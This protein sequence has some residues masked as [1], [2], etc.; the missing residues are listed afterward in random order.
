MTYERT[1]ATLASTDDQGDLATSSETGG[2]LDGHA[3]MAADDSAIGRSTVAGTWSGF[4][5]DTDVLS[6]RTWSMTGP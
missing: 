1:L 3:M 4:A 2:G 5:L 6:P